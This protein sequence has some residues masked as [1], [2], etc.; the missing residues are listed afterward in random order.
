M[1]AFALNLMACSE[2]PSAAPEAPATST[3]APAESRATEAPKSAARPTERATH[4]ARQVYQLDFTLAS[5]EPGKPTQIS[6]H[7]L[8]VE[9]GNV[10][11]TRLGRNVPLVTTAHGPGEGPAAG[12][13]A[14]RGAAART[15][16]GFLLRCNVNAT[17]DDLLLR[18]DVEL[19]SIGETAAIEKVALK[20]DALVSP[21]KKTLV[22]S[23]ED[24]AT[25]KRY[26]L[27][28]VA[29][30][31]RLEL[32]L[33]APVAMTRAVASGSVVRALKKKGGGRKRAR[34]F[35][36]PKSPTRVRGAWGRSFRTSTT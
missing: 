20:G 21:G 26:E 13:A 16:V 34:S 25:H 23:S 3:M 1:I 35:G 9:D 7:R 6:S 8:N 19:S 10:G 5:T 11:E 14:P 28:V 32:A 17:G 24:P 15:D 4:E 27:S 31:L 29:T 36:A 2:T 22:S 30:Q 18:S 33:T 12:Q